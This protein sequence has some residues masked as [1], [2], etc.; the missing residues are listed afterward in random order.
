MTDEGERRHEI[1]TAQGQQ[2]VWRTAGTY[3]RDAF[4]RRLRE[5]AATEGPLLR[6][7]RAMQTIYPAAESVTQA[8]R[9]MATAYRRLGRRRGLPRKVT[10]DR[11]KQRRRQSDG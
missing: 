2:S 9:E 4:E 11:A 6:I 7:A 3:D 10:R 8:L 1:L 5:L